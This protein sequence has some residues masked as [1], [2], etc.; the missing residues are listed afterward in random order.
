MITQ[1]GECVKSPRKTYHPDGY[2]IDDSFDEFPSGRTS[3]RSIRL[4]E[5]ISTMEV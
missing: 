2:V 1:N 3:K 5:K 4:N